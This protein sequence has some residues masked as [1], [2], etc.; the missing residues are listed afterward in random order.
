MKSIK[1]ISLVTILAMGC[2]CV[3]LILAGAGAGAGTYAYIK[4]ELKVEYPKS[5][6]SVWAATLKALRD[7]NITIVT[8]A[9]DGISGSIKARRADDTAVRIN[10]ENKV[11]GPTILKIRAGVFGDKE[12]SL[13]IKK[14]IDRHLGIS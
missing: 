12:A 1:V 11:S 2:G 9:K 4:G 14:A 13:I 7:G 5:Y 8:K 3:P 10:V 6:E